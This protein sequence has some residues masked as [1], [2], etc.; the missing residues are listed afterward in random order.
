MLS[1]VR[2]PTETR[3]TE[4]AGMGNLE[5]WHARLGAD[6]VLAQSLRHEHDPRLSK[7]LEKSAAR[8]CSATT[9]QRSPS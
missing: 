5:V 7:K 1:P 8:A 3:M 9:S 2:E 4:F 6:E